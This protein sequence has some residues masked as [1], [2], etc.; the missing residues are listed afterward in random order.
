MNKIE[1]ILGHRKVLVFGKKSPQ[2]SEEAG[3]TCGRTITDQ[4]LLAML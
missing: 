1:Q 3:V 4:N 2:Y